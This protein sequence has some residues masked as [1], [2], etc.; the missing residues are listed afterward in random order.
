LHFHEGFKRV[1]SVR[2][3][4]DSHYSVEYDNQNDYE[5]LNKGSHAFFT[6]TYQGKEEG[7]GSSNQQ[8]YDQHIL[9]YSL[10]LFEL[11]KD[12]SEL[13]EHIREL[14]P[15][16]LDCSNY[17]AHVHGSWGYDQ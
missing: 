1:F 2:F 3:L 16:S 14:D 11:A 4:P 12:H 6:V 8:D 9:L 17:A 5:G 7:D 13:D 10:N 15:F